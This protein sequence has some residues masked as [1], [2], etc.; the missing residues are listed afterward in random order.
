MAMEAGAATNVTE[1]ERVHTVR[2]KDT[3]NVKHVRVLE[4]VENARARGK[5]GAPIAMVKE[6]ALIVKEKNSLLVPVAMEQENFKHTKSIHSLKV[7][8][9]RNS[10]LCK[11]T[12]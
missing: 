1:Q 6:F 9:I 12:E 7:K 2:A 10:V 4:N 5:Y 3:F 11:L 8:Q